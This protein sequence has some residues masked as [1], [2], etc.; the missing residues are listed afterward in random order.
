M[1]PS[2]EN[3]R[4]LRKGVARDG[5]VVFESGQR[6]LKCTISDISTTG[7]GVQVAASAALPDTLH[8]ISMTDKRAYA[9]IVAWRKPGSV[10]L[11]FVSVFDLAKLP[12]KDLEYLTRIWLERSRR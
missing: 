1:A 11:K 12:S 2:S 7:A 6:Q 5:V 10:G 4:A 3:R 9:A 8:L